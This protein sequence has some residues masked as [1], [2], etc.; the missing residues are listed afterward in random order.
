MISRSHLSA[1]FALLVGLVA[2]PLAPAQSPTLQLRTSTAKE[3]AVAPGGVVTASVVVTNT[4]SAEEELLDLLTLPPGCQRV[5]PSGEPFRLAPGAMTLRVLAVSIAANLGAGRHTLQYEVR[6]QKTWSTR[7]SVDLTVRVTPVDRLEFTVEPRP[8]VVLAGDAYPIRLRVTNRGNSR[9]AVQLT[10]RSSHGFPVALEAGAFGLAPGGERVLTASVATD[11][12]FAKH[13][14]HAVTFEVTAQSASGQKLSASQASV[15]ELIPLVSGPR[16]NRHYLPLQLRTM[17]LAESG[18]GARLQTELSGAGS[19]DEAGK[20]QIDIVFRGPDIKDANLYGERAEYGASYH[21]EHWHIDLGDR[22]YSLTPLTERHALGRGAGLRWQGD[23]L[24]LGAFYFASRYRRVNT[25][26]LGAFVRRD[27]GPDF[28]LQASFLRKWGGGEPGAALPQNIFSLQAHYRRGQLLDLTL[29]AA[30]SRSDRGQ[31]DYAYRL[32]AR[33]EL[34]GKFVY[35]LEHTHAGPNFHGYYSDT[36]STIA[37]L[38]KVLGPRLHLRA[39]LAHFSDN[40]ALNDQRSSVVNR[41]SSWSVGGDFL[42]T[43]KTTFSLEWQRV[44][45]TDIL[46]PAAYDFSSHALRLGAE[47]Q[48]GAFHLKGSIELGQLD[49]ALSGYHGGFQRYTFSARWQPSH[50]QS[51]TVYG[52]Y[53]PNASSGSTETALSLGVQAH[54]ILRDQLDVTLGYARNQFNGLTGREQDEINAALRYQF[55]DKSSLSLVARAFRS[56]GRAFDSSSAASG[57]AVLVTYTVPLGM[58]VSR[59]TSVGALQGR[60]VHATKGA[61]AGLARVVVQIGEQFAVTDVAGR[62]EFPAL[63]PGPAELRVVPDSLGPRLALTTP[64]PMRV[65][66]RPAETTHVDLHAAEAGV[67]EVRVLRQAFA[68]G[69]AFA[70]H[71]SL[72]EIGGAEGVALEVSNGR[73]VWRAQTDRTGFAT[74]TRLPTGRWRVRAALAELP[75]LT[76]LEG[77]DQSFTLAPGQTRRVALRLVPQRRTLQMLERGKIE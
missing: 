1:V 64:M 53:G 23:G 61:A 69:Q 52:S 59:K 63:P 36:D 67:I 8:D 58:P 72:R 76:T 56:V 21:G 55:K 4:G 15:V 54:W 50:R 19:L 29:E 2:A 70:G 74:F 62:F 65:Q 13:T 33:G 30:V 7:V 40:L 71:P 5:A 46:K 48:V 37:T 9:L 6:S 75:P 32:A 38:S 45:R 11:R 35:S 20:H 42:Y 49:N 68:D 28:S 10:P 17:L 22:T 12:A 77:A 34:P 18:R 25:E 57:A 39:S 14:H 31:V 51:Y 24:T 66:I 44:R 73:E 27:F 60:L 26:E 3:L 43:P 41:E 47:H 16:D